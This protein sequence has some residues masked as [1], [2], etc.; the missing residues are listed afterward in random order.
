MFICCR[1]SNIYLNLKV[2][3]TKYNDISLF[4]ESY[5]NKLIKN[6]NF[7]LKVNFYSQTKN[8]SRNKIILHLYL[9]LPYRTVDVLGVLDTGDIAPALLAMQCCER[10]PPV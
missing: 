3:P 5:C 6:L 10:C 8:H 4:I 1:N 9:S 7:I 2:K